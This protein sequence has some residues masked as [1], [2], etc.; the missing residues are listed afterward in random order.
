MRLLCLFWRSVY[1]RSGH[2]R[3]FLSVEELADLDE[4][5]DIDRVASGELVR[6]LRYVAAN[7][8]SEIADLNFAQWVRKAFDASDC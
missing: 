4:R 1:R 5:I 2:P 3:V 7:I 8:D 6:G